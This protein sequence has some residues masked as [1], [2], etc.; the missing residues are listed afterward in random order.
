MTT[1]AFHSDRSLLYQYAPGI[2]EW[3]QL[4]R[5]SE[6]FLLDYDYFLADPMPT[7]PHVILVPG[8]VFYVTFSDRPS[9]SFFNCIVILQTT[10]Q[11]HFNARASFK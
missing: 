2:S 9:V 3:S 4:I 8:I 6:I 1:R 10:L 11:N 7:M 5:H